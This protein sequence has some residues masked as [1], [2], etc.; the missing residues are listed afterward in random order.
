MVGNNKV[1]KALS[2]K[3]GVHQGSILSPLFNFLI[4][5]MTLN[6]IIDWKKIFKVDVYWK[7]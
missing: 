1:S 7:L 5:N 2:V 3:Y 6:D 4:N